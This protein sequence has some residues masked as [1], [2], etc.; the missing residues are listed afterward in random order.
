MRIE[1]KSELR[2]PLVKENRQLGGSRKR[3]NDGNCFRSGILAC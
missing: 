2:G 3:R 1:Q